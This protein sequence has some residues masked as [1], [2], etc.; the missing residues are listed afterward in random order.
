MGCKQQEGKE[1]GG[2]GDGFMLADNQ[3][4]LPCPAAALLPAQRLSPYV[5]RVWLRADFGAA[6]LPDHHSFSPCFPCL[7][8]TAAGL[9]AGI[10]HDEVFVPGL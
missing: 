4:P 10:V 9:G 8:L 3:L 2:S 6:S 5:A 7:F 1:G